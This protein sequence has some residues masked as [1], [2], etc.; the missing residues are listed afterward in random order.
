MR[1][2]IAKIEYRNARIRVKIVG[3]LSLPGITVLASSDSLLSPGAR[4]VTGA[5]IR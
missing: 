2:A 3:L 1:R 5:T 4:R